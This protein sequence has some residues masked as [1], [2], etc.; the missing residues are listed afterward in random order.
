MSK[1]L[2]K[3]A[4]SYLTEI[5]GIDFSDGEENIPEERDKY[6]LDLL[7]EK[8]LRL[9]KEHSDEHFIM[10]DNAEEIQ[11]ALLSLTY[12]KLTS[13]SHGI[14]YNLELRNHQ[15][16]VVD[17]NYSDL[18]YCLITLP[19]YGNEGLKGEDHGHGY[20]I[21]YVLIKK[22]KQK[23]TDILLTFN[24]NETTAKEHTLYWE[25]HGAGISSHPDRFG[26]RR[27]VAIYD[28][29]CSFLDKV[30]KSNFKRPGRGSESL[31][32]Q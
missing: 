8:I 13:T 22:S 28:S 5:F 14:D 2:S 16:Y 10:L 21:H 3:Q 31:W 6:F 26:K 25:P 30:S 15:P 23:R 9:R 27:R 18:F 7:Q 32:P 19:K 1:M 20:H 12:S 29:S 17:E 4:I 11:S 24:P